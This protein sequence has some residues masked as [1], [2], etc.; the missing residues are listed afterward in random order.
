MI[1]HTLGIYKQMIKDNI[2]FNDEQKSV[3]FK[4]LGELRKASTSVNTQDKALFRQQV[5]CSKILQQLEGK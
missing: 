5:E 2:F 1:I 3:I 4:T